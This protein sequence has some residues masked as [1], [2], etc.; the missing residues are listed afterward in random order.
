MP[1][2]KNIK[3]RRGKQTLIINITLISL[4]CI[5]VF[6]MVAVSFKEEK[7]INYSS[8]NNV[9]PTIQQELPKSTPIPK[10]VIQE[11]NTGSQPSQY[12][13]YFEEKDGVDENSFDRDSESAVE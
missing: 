10:P 1:Q 6:F 3:E 11:E 13:I 2:K 4:V 7:T 5:I 9:K 8:E 12:Q